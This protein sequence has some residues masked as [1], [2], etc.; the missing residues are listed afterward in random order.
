VSISAFQPLAVGGWPLADKLTAKRKG[1][2]SDETPQYTM[3]TYYM[4]FLRKGPA[5]SPEVTPEVLTIHEG[6]MANLRRLGQMGKLL[7]AGPFLD[8]GDLRGM[9]LFCTETQAEAEELAAADPAII[10]GRFQLEIHPVLLA[11]E[12]WAVNSGQ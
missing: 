12:V 10:A 6:H 1:K 11:K 4:G 2:M 5:W 9:L 7:V 8:G 3:T